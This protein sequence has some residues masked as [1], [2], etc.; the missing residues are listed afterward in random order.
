MAQ[1]GEINVRGFRD[2][3]F[4][5]FQRLGAEVSGSHK[6]DGCGLNTLHKFAYQLSAPLLHS[7]ALPFPHPFS[8]KSDK[9]EKAQLPTSQAAYPFSLPS[10]PAVASS[11]LFSWG[12]FFHDCL[13][14]AENRVLGPTLQRQTEKLRR[15]K[16]RRFA[17]PGPSTLSHLSAPRA[18]M[19]GPSAPPERPRQLSATTNNFPGGGGRTLGIC[20]P[21]PD[22]QISSGQITRST[23]RLPSL[24]LPGSAWTKPGQGVCWNGPEGLGCSTSP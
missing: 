9:Q 22:H 1:Q 7:L 15:Q 10:F 20:P 21:S 23:R 14:Q 12:S 17:A 16:A 2:S 19:P 4:S 8:H 13:Y 5:Q 6:F 3:F 24:G 11:A 18:S